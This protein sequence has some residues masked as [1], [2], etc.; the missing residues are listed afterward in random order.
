MG[1][2]TPSA[3]EQVFEPLRHTRAA[4][5][6]VRRIGEAIGSGVLEPGE[7]LPSESDL[8]Q[9]LGVAPMTL[10][11]AVAALREAGFI[12]TQRGR[13]GGTF[14]ALDARSA[15][16]PAP[17]L[18]TATGWRELTTWRRA[19]SGEAA[20]EA[21]RRAGPS[22]R[23]A[24]SELAA[25]VGAAAT[26]FPAFRRS[27]SRLHLAFAEIAGNRR[28]IAAEAAIQAELA[29]ILAAVPAPAVAARLSSAGHEPILA[30]IAASDPASARAAM[31]I[32]VESTYDWIAGFRLGLV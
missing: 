23:A 7:R 22:E 11:Q 2:D 10:R 30:A 18:P 24:L 9:M 8:A 25:A 26:D 20:S 15:L 17:I 31:E 14:V 5:A 13:T 21:A 28:L 29:D 27:D 3:R 12:T 6:I 1:A 16:K 19:V 32:H 4:E